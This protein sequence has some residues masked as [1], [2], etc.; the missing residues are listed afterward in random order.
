VRVITL[1]AEAIA[2][3]CLGVP[4][5]NTTMLGALAATSGLLRLDSAESG[6]RH[7]MHPAQAEKNVRALRRAA[8]E[9]QR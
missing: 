4:I 9:V 5:V 2:L 1:D 3:E 8:Q 7:E 6:I